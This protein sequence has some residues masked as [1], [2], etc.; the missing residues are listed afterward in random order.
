M[1]VSV[2]N[3]CSSRADMLAFSSEMLTRNAGHAEYRYFVLTWLPSPEVVTWLDGTAIP[4]VRVQYPT[5]QAEYLPQ[6]RAMMNRGFEVGYEHADWVALVNTD[7]AF[8][9]D[10]LGN[11]VKHATTPDRIPNST[12][13]T[14]IHGT[15][16]TVWGDYGVPTEA[17]FDTTGFWRHHDELFEDEVETD[18][19]RK[20]G[21]EACASFPYLIHRKWWDRC[22]P[23]GL[24]FHGHGDAPDRA[25]FRR[26]HHEGAEF[27][28]V[29]DSIVYHHEA[30]ERRGK[31][32]AGAELMPE[33]A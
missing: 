31:R 33:G 3:F 20:G 13:I 4:L 30:V 29:H 2:V 17:T 1:R 9:R 21:W 14:P 11:L 27:L 6:L 28:M 26:C 23:W 22:G 5:T 25:F 18:R 15:G 12:H 16:N 10:W 19:E 8:G 7:M 32:P 24:R